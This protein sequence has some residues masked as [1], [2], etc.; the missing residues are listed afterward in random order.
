[1][2][3]HPSRPRK[4]RSTDKFQIAFADTRPM[5]IDAAMFSTA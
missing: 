5:P 2:F 4:T 1:M 3:R